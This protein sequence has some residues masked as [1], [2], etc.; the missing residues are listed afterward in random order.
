M[1]KVYKTDEETGLRM[2]DVRH[3]DGRLRF[4]ALESAIVKFHVDAM[5]WLQRCG[6]PEIQQLY[7]DKWVALLGDGVVSSGSRS[8]VWEWLKVKYDDRTR[9][10]ILLAYVSKAGERVVAP[11]GPPFPKEVSDDAEPVWH[12]PANNDMFMLA[13]RMDD[14]ERRFGGSPNATEVNDRIGKLE[15]VLTCLRNE[16]IGR[17][18][19]MELKV[20]D[21]L[22]DETCQKI[23][24]KLLERMHEELEKNPDNGNEEDAIS[25]GQVISKGGSDKPPR[26][27]PAP[28]RSRSKRK[29][30]Q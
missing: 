15:W 29:S 9:D 2:I 21:P 7:G 28:K 13:R 10:M 14:L 11:S 1:P 16:L 26:K 20:A 23:S 12:K 27:S 6:D 22:D 8:E 17:I 25:L 5:N 3:I 4:M 19:D 24:R 18:E 30:D